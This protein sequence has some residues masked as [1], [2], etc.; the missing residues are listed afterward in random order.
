MSIPTLSSLPF[1]IA[2]HF[3]DYFHFL[4]PENVDVVRPI[5]QLYVHQAE[6]GVCLCFVWYVYMRSR[7]KS[8]GVGFFPPRFS[9]RFPLFSFFLK[10]N[11][12]M[13]CPPNPCTGVE[14][15]AERR[16]HTAISE[17]DSRL[18]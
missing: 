15:A 18:F 7:F 9:F 8:E 5:G 10:Y 6:P 4:H 11:F 2:S 3:F 14:G 13:A 16:C 17:G 1:I 12:Y